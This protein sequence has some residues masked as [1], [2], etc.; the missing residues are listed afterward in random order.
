M[1]ENMKIPVK[2]QTI[3]IFLKIFE[4]IEMVKNRQKTSELKS[5]VRLKLTEYQKFLV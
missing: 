3:L 1:P 2:L 4:K 5:R